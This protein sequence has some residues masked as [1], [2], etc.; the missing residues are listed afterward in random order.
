MVWISTTKRPTG[1]RASSVRKTIFW[2]RIN[3]AKL[4]QICALRNGQI[5]SWLVKT[6]GRINPNYLSYI[7]RDIRLLNPNW[8]SFVAADP[9]QKPMRSVC[10]SVCVCMWQVKY[11]GCCC[12]GHTINQRK[13]WNTLLGSTNKN[14]IQFDWLQATL[15]WNMAYFCPGIIS[16]LTVIRHWRILVLLST[17]INRRSS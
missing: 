11:R 10:L 5:S 7:S 3:T 4:Q 2:R 6:I 15:Y 13:T 16:L 9:C 14:F 1:Q 12:Y 17:W 8:D